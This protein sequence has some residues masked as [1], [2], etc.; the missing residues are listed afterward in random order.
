VLSNVT[1][2]YFNNL[3]K[4]IFMFG[5]DIQKFV[6]DALFAEW[7]VT[8]SRSLVGCAGLAAMCTCQLTRDLKDYPVTIMNGSSLETIQMNCHCGLGI[9]RKCVAAETEGIAQNHLR[10][11][12]ALFG[13]HIGDDECRRQ[14]LQ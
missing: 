13:I 6:G 10:S 9:G 1:D 2:E 7:R 3:V 8:P 4:L 5:G 11:F 14:Y 12:A